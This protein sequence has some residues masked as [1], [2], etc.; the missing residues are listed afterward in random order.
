MIAPKTARGVL[1]LTALVALTYW[2]SR[3]TSERSNAPIPGLDTRLDYALQDFEMQFYDG[4]GQPSAHLRAPRL[5]NDAESG[6][7]QI[8]RPV[9]DIIDRGNIWLINAES[10]TVSADRQR[11]VLQGDVRMKRAAEEGQAPLDIST[12]ELLLQ[13]ATRIASSERRVHIAEGRD[14]ME[15]LGFTIDMTVNR[16]QLSDQVKLRYAVNP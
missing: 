14:T 8:S 12:S 9:F 13:I 6:I 7:A 10:A 1:V 2:A 5:A 4:L 11:V 15:A 16:F 3:S